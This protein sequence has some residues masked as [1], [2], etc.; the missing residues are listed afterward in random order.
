MKQPNNK[1]QFIITNELAS[2]ILLNRIRYSFI[3]QFP[4]VFLSCF[5]TGHEVIKKKKK[6]LLV[7]YIHGNSLKAEKRRK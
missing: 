1:H 7:V 3:V 6:L 2:I 4:A 5:T